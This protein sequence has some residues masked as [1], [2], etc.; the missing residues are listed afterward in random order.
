MF[1]FRQCLMERHNKWTTVTSLKNENKHRRNLLIV[2]RYYCIS[3]TLY[4]VMFVNK[5]VCILCWVF[6]IRYLNSSGK[7]Q[8]WNYVSTNRN[9]YAKKREE[10][11][12]WK[13]FPTLKWMRIEC[14]IVYISLLIYFI[15][16]FHSIFYLQSRLRSLEVWPG[17]NAFEK[18]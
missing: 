11:V 17:V 4:F 16:N 13:P 3:L 9:R 2:G 1:N 18:E 14:Q 5:F 6:E 12:S 7:V 8:N 10:T 15:A